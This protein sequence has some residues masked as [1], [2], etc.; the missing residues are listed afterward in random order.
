MSSPIRRPLSRTYIPHRLVVKFRSDGPARLAHSAHALLAT[1]G[2]GPGYGTYGSAVRLHRE[3]PPLGL[4][5]LFFDRRG[6]DHPQAHDAQDRLVERVRARYPMRTRRAPGTQVPDLTNFYVM[7]FEDAVVAAAYRRLAR[8]EPTVESAEYDALGTLLH[9]PDDPFFRSRGSWGQDG[10]DLWGLKKIRADEA[11]DVTRGEGV[12]VAVVDTG[13]DYDHPDIAANVWTNPYPDADGNGFAGDVRGWNFADGN[14]DPMDRDNAAGHGTHV[15]GIVAAVGDNGLGVIGVAPGARVMAVKHATGS[16]TAVASASAAA[17]VYAACNG[18]DVINNSWVLGGDA[19]A[20]AAA[21]RFAHTLGVVVIFATGNDGTLLPRS[22]LP[23]LRETIKVAATIPDDTPAE[24]S[25]WGPLVDVAAPGGGTPSAP[26]A[27]PE[28]RPQHS[29][30][31][32]RAGS[33]AASIVREFGVG[34]GYLRAFGTSAAAPHVAGLAALILAHRPELTNEGVRQVLR[35][36][37]TGGGTRFNFR[38]GYGRIDAAAALTVEGPPDVRILEPADGLALGPSATVVRVC[39]VVAGP[40]V[41]DFQLSYSRMDDLARRHPIGPPGRHA[42]ARHLHDWDVCHLRAGAYLLRLAVTNRDGLTFED[43]V[44]VVRENPAIVRLADDGVSRSGLRAAGRWAAWVQD[45]DPGE[46]AAPE[47]LLLDLE[48]R[49]TRTL[50]RFKPGF[51]SVLALTEGSVAYDFVD[52]AGTSLRLHDLSSDRVTAVAASAETAT[53]FRHVAVSKATVVWVQDTPDGNTS[54]L[55]RTVSSETTTLAVGVA[56]GTSGLAMDGVTVVR[57]SGQDL[58]LHDL[59]AGSNRLLAPDGSGG[60]RTCPVIAGRD[61]LWLEAAG[62]GRIDIRHH[63][64]G[65]GSTRTVRRNLDLVDSLSASQGRAAWADARNGNPDVYLYD[66]AADAETTVTAG[67][68]AQNGPAIAG[69]RVVW[70]EGD[71]GRSN[72]GL[73]EIPRSG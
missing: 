19:A 22:G 13:I 15:A 49:K 12:V 30:L 45:G 34:D 48:T 9:L 21:V 59:A 56:A 68:D 42:T 60:A 26:R 66:L 39:G 44:R 67:F 1:E 35:A 3:C 71:G 37:S 69:S 57:T 10:D 20:V 43:T 73:L 52:D 53:P 38:T 7:E 17:L 64:L 24:F 28:Q 5:G 29:I 63:D 72:V 36:S 40:L 41:R 11:W 27:G 6:V 51:P 32:L 23:A 65:T 62:S 33:V 14:N 2:A 46:D 50:A 18:A 31:S 54:V 47:L 55:A 61:V 4:R 25:T 16:G 8:T 70:L 58:V